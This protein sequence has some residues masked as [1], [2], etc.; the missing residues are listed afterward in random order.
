MNPFIEGPGVWHDFH[1]RLIAAIA[2]DLGPRIRPRFFVR[3]DV[4][5]QFRSLDDPHDHGFRPD[6]ALLERAGLT[7]T[8]AAAAVLDAPVEVGMIGPEPEHEGYLRIVD[9]K[10]RRL[11]TVLE[12]L[13]PANKLPGADHDDYMRRRSKLLSSGAN[14]VEIDL[15][16]RGP[17]IPV[18]N[19][20]KSPYSLLVARPR[21]WPRAGLWP[22][23]LREPIPP[24]PIPLDPPDDTVRL[25]LQPLIHQI[26][27]V[28]FYEDTI[29]GEIPSPR[30]SPEDEA[31]V[32]SLVPDRGRDV[33]NP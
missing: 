24:I 4:R 22:I 20:P 28:A 2:T 23:G 13:S 11:V 18:E 8:P 32:L 29:Y 27:D 33:A 31:W 17:P 1:Q 6:V 25:N 12:V 3:I 10:S 21:D 30:L 5:L 9:A 15:I 7:T 14:L 16:R 19:R 26:Y